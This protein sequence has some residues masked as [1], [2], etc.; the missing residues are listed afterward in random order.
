MPVLSVRGAF[1]FLVILSLSAG[2]KSGDKQA[3]EANAPADAQP[4]ADPGSAA[5]DSADA[6][7][8]AEVPTKIDISAVK[9][10]GRIAMFVPAPTEF[11]AALQA[12]NIKIDIRKLVK[13]SGRSLEGKNRSIIALETGVRLSNNQTGQEKVVECA[14]VFIAIGHVPNTQIFQGKLEM[15]H[16]GYITR[17]EGAQT[18]VRG[19][20][21]AGDCSDKI[22]R[23]AITAAGM[24]CAAAIE[25]ER[26][27]ACE[28]Q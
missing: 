14:G 23:Q 8:M 18:S 9:A 19:V 17:I 28:N 3:S 26:F 15:D 25:A 4:A 12:S 7:V 5:P 16:S 11:Q 6:A 1:V 10:E 24:G 22:Y 21:V 27:L 20:F 2:C 13:D